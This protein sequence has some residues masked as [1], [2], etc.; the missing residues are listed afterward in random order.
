MGVLNEIWVIKIRDFI[1]MHKATIGQKLL[2]HTRYFSARVGE[3][4]DMVGYNCKYIF[5]MVSKEYEK[6]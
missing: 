3:S 5:V 2:P 4:E 1:Y 6:R